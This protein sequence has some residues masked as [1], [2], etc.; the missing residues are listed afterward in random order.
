M[1]SSAFLGGVRLL[2]RPRSLCCSRRRATS[3]PATQRVGAPYPGSDTTPT[4]VFH[5]GCLPV[6]TI[7]T[8]RE[9]PGGILVVF[10]TPAHY[11]S[12]LT[13]GRACQRETTG[14]HG[15]ELYA[16][17]WQSTSCQ[18]GEGQVHRSIVCVER[19]LLG[20]P[21]FTLVAFPQLGC[22]ALRLAIVRLR[23]LRCLLAPPPPP[24]HTA[25]SSSSL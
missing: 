1:V 18:D 8:L 11:T 3:S 23:R 2:S 14:G 4:G 24:G 15:G 16:A 13:R 17:T 6:T 25:A 7:F 22:P 20:P 10:S 21:R 19:K 9:H 12:C 5:D